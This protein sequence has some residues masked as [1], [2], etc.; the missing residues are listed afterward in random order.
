MIHIVRN[1]DYSPSFEAIQPIEVA[2]T[3]SER[4]GRF[5]EYKER[6]S[7]QT[8]IDDIA[9]KMR[10]MHFDKLE[11]YDCYIKEWRSDASLYHFECDLPKD[12]GLKITLKGKKTNNRLMIYGNH[13]GN[14]HPEFSVNSSQEALYRS[15]VCH[16]KKGSSV[17]EPN[18]KRIKLDVKIEPN[19]IRIQQ[20][21]DRKRRSKHKNVQGHR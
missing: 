15:L 16:P 20:T 12:K 17:G 5:F 14:T 19:K 10:N 6:A 9:I 21:Q 2:T 1:I 7:C 11:G 13:T 8:G 3:S 4:D 18:S